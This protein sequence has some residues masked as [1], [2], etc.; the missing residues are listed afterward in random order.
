MVRR[1]YLRR[2]NV[3]GRRFRRVIVD[4]H[5]EKRHAESVTD[6]L[7]LE[8]VQG[9][10][11]LFLPLIKELPTGYLVFVTELTHASGKPYRLVWT[12][13][14]AHDYLGVINCFR[15]KEKRHGEK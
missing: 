13:H 14:P 2:L 6:S 4:S 1:T 8:L 3:N 15:I 11:G 10:N 7:V 9:L 12:Y 5:Y